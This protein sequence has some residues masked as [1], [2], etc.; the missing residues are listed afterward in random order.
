MDFCKVLDRSGGF[1]GV[2]S[3]GAELVA[4]IGGV[5]S[6]GG[7]MGAREGTVLGAGRLGLLDGINVVL[8]MGQYFP[9]PLS[10]SHFGQ[11]IFL[12]KAMG[13][14]EEMGVV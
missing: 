1:A 6:M 7:C 3:F 10:S 13:G 9:L 12:S 4:S 5:L 2:D 11:Y 14:S 8:Q